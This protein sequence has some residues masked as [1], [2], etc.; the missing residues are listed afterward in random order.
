MKHIM[1]G[2]AIEKAVFGWMFSVRE[3]KCRTIACGICPDLN[4][5]AISLWR[6]L[7]VVAN[8]AG[9]GN[10]RSRSRD[11]TDAEDSWRAKGNEVAF[12]LLTVF[13]IGPLIAIKLAEAQSCPENRAASLSGNINAAVAG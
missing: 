2:Y 4:S 13:R 6:I 7:A 3:E 10:W 12:R 11:L 1:P 5:M 8:D 9:P